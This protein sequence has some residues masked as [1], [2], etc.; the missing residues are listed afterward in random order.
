MFF[1]ANNLDAIA[2]AFEHKSRE[3]MK[4]AQASK[5]VDRVRKQGEAYGWEQAAR[6]LRDLKWAKDVAEK[7]LKAPYAIPREPK[8]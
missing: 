4:N 6:M 1:I 3:C 8:E 2:R 5:A 7:D